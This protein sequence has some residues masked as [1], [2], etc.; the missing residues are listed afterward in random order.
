MICDVPCSGLGVIRKKPDIREKPLAQIGALPAVHRRILETQARYVR[1]GGALLYSTCTIVPEE[2]G[3]V[4][5]A[6]LGAHP[7]FTME[8]MRIP[9]E[10][11][12]RGEATLL[13]CVHGTDGFY[14]CLL[15]K[16]A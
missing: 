7:E 2:N 13:P 4:T 11:E 12:N 3:G 14:L 16:Q 5:A 10:K 9:I 1:P 6:F 15:R 8:P